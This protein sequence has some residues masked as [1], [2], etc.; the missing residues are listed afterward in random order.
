[1]TRESIASET[2]IAA[3]DVSFRYGLRTALDR[4]SF[5]AGNGELLGILGP[6]GSGKS[7]LFR[8]IATLLPMQ[9]GSLNVHGFD[10]ARDQHDVRRLL[11]VAFQSPALDPRLTVEENLWCH[12][13]LYGM[14]RGQIR[15]RTTEL[16]TQF[17]V[18][19]RRHDLAASLSGGMK[20]RVELVKCLLHEPRLLLLDEPTSGLDPTARREFWDM[21]T[22][23]RT[24]SKLAVVVATHLMPEAEVCDTLLVM[25]RGSIV[26]RG[27]PAEMLARVTGEKLR[28]RTRN[29]EQAALLLTELV[30]G[31]I[32]HAGDWLTVRVASAIELVPRIM[33]QPD[34]QVQA[35]EIQRP[36]LDDVF[37]VLTGRSMDASETAHV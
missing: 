31:P 25:D 21:L 16:L 27:T 37:H 11:S 34:L 36:S 18:V 9:S 30:G 5:D 33:Q 12:G 35:I 7:T 3:R 28:I 15:D 19:D 29:V 32:E 22:V 2:A 23:H 1:M 26:A 8:L 6:N 4:V 14:S 13:R 10:V 20:R 24:Q 17:R